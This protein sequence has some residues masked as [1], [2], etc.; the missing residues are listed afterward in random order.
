MNSLIDIIFVV[1]FLLFIIVIIRGKYVKTTLISF[2]RGIIEGDKNREWYFVINLKIIYH[3]F[4]NSYK[5]YITIEIPISMLQ[6]IP[7]GFNGADNLEVIGNKNAFLMTD[8]E[9]NDG[10]LII[11]PVR[12]T[13][14]RINPERAILK[15]IQIFIPFNNI[16]WIDNNRPNMMRSN[17]QGTAYITLY[18]R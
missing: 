12:V 9:Q 10:I 17:I 11:L 14:S 2:H 4:K 6:N 15:E 1:C 7:I 8:N 18:C 16:I 13:N 5:Q 3:T